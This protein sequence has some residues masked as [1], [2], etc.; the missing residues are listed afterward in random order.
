MSDNFASLEHQL[1]HVAQKMNKTDEDVG[2][3]F[4]SVNTMTTKILPILSKHS[5]I[6]TITGGFLVLMVPIAATWQFHLTNKLENLTKSVIILQERYRYYEQGA[7]TQNGELA[8]WDSGQIVLEW[9]VSCLQPRAPVEREFPEHLLHPG[10]PLY[11]DPQLQSSMQKEH[12]SST[13]SS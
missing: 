4:D 7:I 6:H 5:I 11:R 13:G 12:V 3:L 10:W 8:R 9:P 2:K 1:T